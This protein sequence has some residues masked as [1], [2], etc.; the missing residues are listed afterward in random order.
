MK[1]RSRAWP[2]CPREN[3]P[4]GLKRIVRSVRRDAPVVV[5]VTRTYVPLGSISLYWRAFAGTSSRR[6]RASPG[7]RDGR[8]RSCRWSARWGGGGRRNPGAHEITA[9]QFP[10]KGRKTLKNL[11]FSLSSRFRSS[12][13]SNSHHPCPERQRPGDRRRTERH[14][15]PGRLVH[16]GGWI[17]PGN[18]QHCH[19]DG[20]RR[21]LVASG[22]RDGIMKLQQR[23]ASSPQPRV[24][25]PPRT[26]RLSGRHRSYA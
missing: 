20:Q 5:A 26:H 6:G 18:R 1:N 16:D 14:A 3:V 9:L 21:R 2:P 10:S 19:G 17:G 23:E 11:D 4:P 24:P 8:R 13:S 22:V 15:E 7:G 12:P 25:S